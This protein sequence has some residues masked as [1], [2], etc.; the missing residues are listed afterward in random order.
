MEMKVEIGNISSLAA[1]VASISNPAK[2]VQRL[3]GVDSFDKDI[4]TPGLAF[5]AAHPQTELTTIK[6]VPDWDRAFLTSSD[7]VNSEKPEFVNSSLNGFT[8]S[9]GYIFF[10]F[11][12]YRKKLKNKSRLTYI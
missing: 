11:Y 4:I 3:S 12:K 2:T 8:I 10:I 5:L 6:V 1:S 7:D 9:S